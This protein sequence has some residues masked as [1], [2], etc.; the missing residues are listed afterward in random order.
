MD[1]SCESCGSG[2][3]IVRADARFC[4]ASCKQRAY[5]KRKKQETVIPVEMRER[6]RWVRW[7]LKGRGGRMTKIPVQVSGRNASS[8]DPSTWSDFR[9]AAESGIGKGVGFMLGDGIG[10]FDLDHC[11]TG[12]ELA[13][14]AQE[15]LDAVED[16]LF[17]EVSQ[18]GEGLHIFCWMDEQP[19]NARRAHPGVEV[20]SQK[21]FI[22]MTGERY[23]G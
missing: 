16:P 3:L 22:A 8:T 1:K 15:R 10:C 11:F 2:L 4:S 7:I 20:Y 14:W 18:S 5:R 23:D 12:G 6:D 13:D 9:S 17:V 21:R 19:A